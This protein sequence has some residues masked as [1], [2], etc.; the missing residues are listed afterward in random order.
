M[1]ARSPEREEN[2]NL[3]IDSDQEELSDSDDQEDNIVKV[4][5]DQY[6][7]ENISNDYSTLWPLAHRIGE[8]VFRSSLESILESGKLLIRTITWNLCAQ[9]P[10]SVEEL[11]ESCLFNSRK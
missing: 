9:N 10:P 7:S 2:F 5:N 4:N 6:L 3:T 1:P 11:K 8:E